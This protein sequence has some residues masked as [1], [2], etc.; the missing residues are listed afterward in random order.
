MRHGQLVLTVHVTSCH[1]THLHLQPCFG[2]TQ[3]GEA[4]AKFDRACQVMSC[5]EFTAMSRLPLLSIETGNPGCMDRR[6]WLCSCKLQHL[7]R[8][9]R[10]VHA[11]MRVPWVAAGIAKTSFNSIRFAPLSCT[12]A[13][14]KADGY[15]GRGRRSYWIYSPQNNSPRTIY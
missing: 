10:I 12:A 11:C 14:A 2:S 4:G 5:H 13:A 1:A 6:F 8:R 15:A 9:M 7:R 3:A